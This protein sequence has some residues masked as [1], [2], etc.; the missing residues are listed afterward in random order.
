MFQAILIVIGVLSIITFLFHNSLGR[1]GT[2]FL[3]VFFNF[4][5]LIL[6][7]RSFFFTTTTN[8]NLYF[9]WLFFYFSFGFYLDFLS[10]SFVFLILIIT[11]CVIFFS[12]SYM[13]HDIRLVYFLSFLELFMFFM[14][15]L[16]SSSNVVQIFIGWE[17]VGIVSFL[18]INFW[19]FRLDS[20]KGALKALFFNRIGDVGYFLFIVFVLLSQHSASLIFCSYNV[21]TSWCMILFLF[22][23]ACGKSAQLLLYAWLPDAMEGPTPVSSLLH[24][25]TM[26]T[27]GVFLLLR[28]YPIIDFG[29][30]LLIFIGGFTSIITGVFACKKFDIKKII[31]YSTCSQLGLMVAAIGFGCI[32][33]SF[34]HLFIHAFFKCLLFISAGVV[35]HLL[36]DEQD[37][38][39]LLSSF[40]FIPFF[41]FF[42]LIGS[43]SICGF[44]FFSGYYTK[45]YI[46]LNS[47]GYTSLLY[48]SSAITLIYSCRLFLF[49]F[50]LNNFANL[51]LRTDFVHIDFFHSFSMVILSLGSV[52]FGY[53]LSDSFCNIDFTFT[54]SQLFPTISIE[55]IPVS[56]VIVLLFLFFYVCLLYFFVQNKTMFFSL[57]YSKLF[58]LY[59]YI[60]NFELFYP[61]LFFVFVNVFSTISYRYVILCYE[62]FFLDSFFFIAPLNLF[63]SFYSSL[64]LSSKISV[65]FLLYSIFVMLLLFVFLYLQFY[66]NC[67]FIFFIFLYNEIIL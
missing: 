54:S 35:I 37:I 59:E 6:S 21:Q 11:M 55:V 3:L 12:I 43:F 58:Q 15:L 65:K 16:V 27:A 17:G 50:G 52:I 56:Y 51:S 44:L 29:L 24:S 60:M 13:F 20:N 7:F 33:G 39:K 2:I 36:K 63:S 30:Y 31:A 47:I 66:Y 26:V 61:I 5:F 67:I 46:L 10:Y 14:L 4:I 1:N 22:L 25:A 18:L 28:F 23:A 9:D 8:L 41:Y 64:Q 48:I 40:S 32:S 42:L 19:F 45:E 53:I 34:L 49:C 38:R 62:R 57:L